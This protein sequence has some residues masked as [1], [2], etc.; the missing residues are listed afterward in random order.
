MMAATGFLF[1]LG[2]YLLI[3]ALEVAPASVLSPFIYTQLIWATIAG[4]VVFD[5]FPDAYTIV[6]GAV[7]ILSGIYVWHRESLRARSVS[8]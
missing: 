8:H 5:D 1:G 6:G 4:Y 2:Y 7:V 3:R